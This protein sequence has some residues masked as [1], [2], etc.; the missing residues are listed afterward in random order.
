MEEFEKMLL[1]KWESMVENFYCTC[2]EDDDREYRDCHCSGCCGCDCHRGSVGGYDSFEEF[3]KEKI[4]EERARI[5]KEFEKSF[6][7]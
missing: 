7:K 3:R 4:E 6:L 2:Y 1:E 5:A